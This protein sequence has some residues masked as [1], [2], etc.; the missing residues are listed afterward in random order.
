MLV[1]QRWGETT[2]RGDTKLQLVVWFIPSRSLLSEYAWGLSAAPQPP[3]SLSI[4]VNST[5][6]SVIRHEG[7]GCTGVSP[8]EAY[9][10]V[11]SAPKI[12]LTNLIAGFLPNC[13]YWSKFFI[14]MF[15][16]YPSTAPPTSSAARRTFRE[17]KKN[18]L[19]IWSNMGLFTSLVSTDK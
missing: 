7:W 6:V 10:T 16:I 18:H 4:H 17:S 14:F 2:D 15:Q 8:V 3:L 11:V 13:A 12:I 19:I 5:R 9:T 1:C